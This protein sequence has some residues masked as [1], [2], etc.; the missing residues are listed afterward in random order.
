MRFM[1]QCRPPFVR[2]HH[3]IVWK[4]YMRIVGSHPSMNVAPVTL[5][6]RAFFAIAAHIAFDAQTCYTPH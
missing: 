4:S 5:R 6:S 3:C 1:V 2:Y